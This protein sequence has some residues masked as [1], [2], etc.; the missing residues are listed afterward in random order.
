MNNHLPNNRPEKLIARPSDFVKGRIVGA[1]LK[2]GDLAKAAGISQP[3]LSNYLRGI[4]SDRRVQVI[5]WDAFCQLTGSS[6]PLAE[7]WGEM[8][9]QGRAA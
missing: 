9:S 2:L 3:S 8:L 4:R 1:G 6:I 5:I 7:F